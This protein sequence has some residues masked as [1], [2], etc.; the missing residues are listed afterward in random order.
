MKPTAAPDDLDHRIQRAV[1]AGIEALMT[2]QV[3]L[4][5]LAG[6][7]RDPAEPL[8]PQ[9]EYVTV[10]IT[11]DLLEGMNKWGAEAWE[12]VAILEASEEH[13]MGCLFKRRKVTAAPANGH[14]PTLV[15][16]GQKIFTG[17]K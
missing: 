3:N 7:F 9:W 14:A 17:S 2:N 13:G 11:G 16:M 12:L 6:V 15:T 10:Q 4:A 8:R 1:M 5:K